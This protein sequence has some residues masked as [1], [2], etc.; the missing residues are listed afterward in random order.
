MFVVP[1]DLNLI[2]QTTIHQTLGLELGYQQGFG[3]YASKIPTFKTSYFDLKY[4]R[5][6][7]ISN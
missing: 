3:N 5:I 1:S 2:I 7:I 6:I 4:R